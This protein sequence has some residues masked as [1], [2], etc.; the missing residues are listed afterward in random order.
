MGYHPTTRNREYRE[1][2][3]GRRRTYQC[4]ECGIKFQTDILN[5]LPEI[6]RVCPDCRKRTM[7]FTFV[8]KNTGKEKQVR[9][10]DVELA[11]LKAWKINCNLTFKVPQPKRV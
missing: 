5:P 4:R 6:D 1:G 10:G 11:T 8:N 2:W 3:L 9:A 7:V